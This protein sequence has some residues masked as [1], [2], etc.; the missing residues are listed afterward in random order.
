MFEFGRLLLLGFGIVVTYFSLIVTSYS[1][2][3]NIWKWKTYNIAYEKATNDGKDNV[4]LSCDPVLLL[5]GFGV[6]TFHQHRLIPQLL[7]T[8]DGE[9]NMVI[10]GIDYLGQ[11]CSWPI[12]CDD[13]NSSNEAGLAYSA[14]T[15]ANQIISFLEC[16]VLPAH[17]GHKVHLVG[18]SVG[19]HISVLLAHER[20]DLVSSVCLLNATPVWG[21]NLPGWDGR[22]PPPP[23]PRQ[24]GRY[25]FDKIRDYDTIEKYLDNAYSNRDAFDDELIHQI[26]QCTEGKGGHAAFASIL[27]SP[28]ATFDGNFQKNFYHELTELKCDVLLI[29]GKNDPWCSPAFGR[30]MMLHL[31]EREKK[32]I[33][34]IP[35]QR[36]IELDN[37]GHCP[38]HEAPTSVGIITHRWIHAKDRSIE[39]LTLVDNDVRVV[40]EPWG[41]ITA[42]EVLRN[43][44]TFSFMD[45]LTTSLV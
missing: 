30:K 10:Y 26:R 35:I 18:N 31:L 34:P 22:L 32:S 3:P 21:L 14:D 9:D 45:R 23:I 24:I 28:P 15:W 36:Y 17:P 41:R 8:R 33:S 27:F 44:L 38:N 42:E 12:E 2:Q 29:F 43:D 19:G 13:G 1:I 16:V 37:V 39:H 5:N 6:G 20:P 4:P 11:G 25:L 7:S 40:D